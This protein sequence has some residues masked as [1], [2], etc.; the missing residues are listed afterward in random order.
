METLKVFI[1]GTQDDMQSERQAVSGAVRALKHE[2]VMAETYGTLPHPPIHVVREM[3][4]RCDVYVGVYGARYGWKMDSGVSVTEFEFTEFRSR[5]PNRILVYVKDVTPEPEQAAFLTRVQDF[6][7]GYFRRP[8]FQDTAQLATWVQED[9][10]QL[11]A[12]V[13]HQIRGVP[14]PTLVEAYLEQVAAQKPYVLWS[15]RTYIDRTVA[16]T[17][18]LF[19]RIVTRYDPHTP[20]RAEKAEPEPLEQALACKAKLVL[21]GGPGLGKT[22]SLVHLAWEAANRALAAPQGG[23]IPIYVELKYYT[24][25]AELETL[26]ARRVNEILRARNLMLAPDLAESTR[27]L[28]AWLAQSDARFLLLLDGLNEVRPEFHTPVRGALQALLNSPHRVVISCRERDYDE[29]LRDRAAP[30]VLRRLQADEIR[31]YLQRV[32][33]DKGDKLFDEQIRR[34]D[35]MRTLAAN[36]LMLWLISA[37]AQG[38]PEARLPANRGK[39]FQQ[40]VAM[41]PRLRTSEGIRAEV[42]LDIVTTALAKLGFEMQERRW[43]AV[44]LAEIRGWQIPTTGKSLEDTLAQAKDWRFLRSDGRL[45]EPVEFLHQLFVEYFAAVHLSAGLCKEQDYAEV[46][47]ERPF[48]G[49]WD[50][51]IVMLAGISD[52]PAELVQWLGRQVAEKKQGHAAFLVAQCWETTDAVRNLEAGAAVASAL[53]TVLRGSYVGVRLRAV[54]ALGE[55]GA[56]AVES[57]SVALRDPYVNVRC[58]AS[59]ALVRIGGPAVEPLNVALC[60]PITEVRWRAVNALWQIGD[61]RAVEPLITA[62][63]DDPDAEVRWRAAGA[64]GQIGDLRAVEPLC[65]ALRDLDERVRSRAIDALRQLG[66]HRAVKPLS[67]ALRDPNPY[68]CER[69]VDALKQIGAP[70]V[71]PLI[72]A[73]RDPDARMRWRA[74]NALGQIGDPRAVEPLITALRD[75]DARVRRSTAEALGQIGD[76]QALSELKRM[77]LE[78]KGEVL[79]LGRVAGAAQEA[80]EKIRKRIGQRMADFGN[81]LI[82]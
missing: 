16:R 67:R 79:G 44:D 19:A 68:V 32:L 36:P 28:K 62:L 29:S 57:L 10:A 4:E 5:H 9:L 40:F 56:P 73:L 52:R 11:I 43:L 18:D 71:E 47:G 33:G 26:L 24:G 25:E 60:D 69:A 78:D 8:K 50:E 46:L 20:E 58:H 77:V 2:S 66:D 21:L 63:R 37:V 64:L 38:D 82:R 15:D 42:P 35:K 7:Q 80:V 74:A 30:F 14:E 75:P 72:T 59:D 22:T 55:I 65:A 13:W 12:R 31:D 17:E 81:S 61:P 39:L 3:I 49:E 41:M 27:I 23:E 76:P 34:D 48:S 45:G 53:R 70:A 6:K 54:D 1:S 51:A